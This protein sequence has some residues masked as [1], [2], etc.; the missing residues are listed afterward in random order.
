MLEVVSN[1]TASSDDTAGDAN[2]SGIIRDRMN[3]YTASAHLHIV[4][5]SDVAKNFGPRADNNVAA[6]RRMTLAPFFT[7]ATQ[8]DS[9]VEDDIV[10]NDCGLT[11]YYSHSVVDEKAPANGCSR[12]NLDSCEHSGDLGNHAGQE[13]E[14]KLVERMCQAMQKNGVQARVADQHLESAGCCRVFPEDGV[15]LFL[16]GAPHKRLDAS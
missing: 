11:D 4:A 14:A 16:N 8:C 10:S 2:D 7:S 1:L 15:N 13:P 6:D 5:Q 12:M 9:L 3:D